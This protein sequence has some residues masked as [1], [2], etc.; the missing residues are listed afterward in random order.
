MIGKLLWLF[1]YIGTGKRSCTL[2]LLQL[3]SCKLQ[4]FNRNRS[5]T[6]S[7]KLCLSKNI[8]L[9]VFY[10]KYQGT[11]QLNKICHILLEKVFMLNTMS[12]RKGVTSSKMLIVQIRNSNKIIFDLIQVLDSIKLQFKMCRF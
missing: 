5:L 11:S 6:S 2:F 10:E 3:R 1:G 7:L 8:N 9:T 4:F 12:L